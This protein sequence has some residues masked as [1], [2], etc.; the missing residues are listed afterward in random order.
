VIFIIVVVIGFIPHAIHIARRE[1]VW[2]KKLFD[3]GCVCVRVYFDLSQA[4]NLRKVRYAQVRGNN[5]LDNVSRENVCCYLFQEIFGFVE[6]LF[7]KASIILQRLM[8]FEDLI[9]TCFLVDITVVFI[10]F[11][12]V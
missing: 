9:N 2:L 12:G 11:V 7:F 5:V 4:C 3:L 1:V 8:E 10:V 6:G